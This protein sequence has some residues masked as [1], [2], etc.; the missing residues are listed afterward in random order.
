[1]CVSRAEYS[2]PHAN[3]G[4]VCI[5]SRVL[6]TICQRMEYTHCLYTPCGVLRRWH[7]VLTL[8]EYSTSHANTWHIC[9]SLAECSTPYASVSNTRT[10]MTHVG[11]PHRAYV[12][13]PVKYSD[14]SICVNGICRRWHTTYT[15]A[16]SRSYTHSFSLSTFTRLLSLSLLHTHTHSFSLF[17]RHTHGLS[18]LAGSPNWILLNID[19]HMHTCTLSFS[20]ARC[21]FLSLA[22]SLTLSRSLFLS[23]A[24]SPQRFMTVF[25]ISRSLLRDLAVD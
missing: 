19:T 11:I 5:P 13:I 4:D 3:M 24:F 20:L 22:H 12:G 14:V 1:M 16:F 17:H 25:R 6:H 15:P 8:V 10:T 23:L 18:S 2:S 21:L 9:V 7:M